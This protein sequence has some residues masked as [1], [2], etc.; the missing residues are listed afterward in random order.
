MTGFG[1]VWSAVWVVAVLAAQLATAPPEPREVVVS[2]GGP[3]TDPAYLPVHAA[4]ALGTFE[5]EGLRVTLRR[6]RH[7]TAALE[8]LRDAEVDVAVTSADQAVRGGWGRGLPVQVL[9]AHTGAPAAMFLVSTRHVGRVGRIEDLPGKR[10]GIPGPGTT[11]HLFLS[12]LLAERRI[13]AWRVE[14]LSFGG[15]TLVARLDSG[16]LAAAIVEEPWATRALAQGAAEIVFDFRQPEVVARYL[17]GP[18]YEVVSVARAPETAEKGKKEAKAEPPAKDR[19]ILEPALTAFARAVIR[20]QHWLAA[21]PAAEVVARLPADLVG[22]PERFVTRLQS[23]QRAYVP[24]GD[25]TAQGLATTL[26]VLRAGS[27]W[28]ATLKVTPE[29]LR[30][31]AFITAARAALGPS[32]A[33]P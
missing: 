17:G 25:A 6:V 24:G 27:P 3:P 10:V 32:P 4:A 20:V 26:R 29:A 1:S 19:A 12:A 31:P 9:L 13:E 33:P 28:P 5:A 30:E 23:A 21:T 22:D 14:L 18:F 7:P 15:A 8:A 2:V 16:N 11:G